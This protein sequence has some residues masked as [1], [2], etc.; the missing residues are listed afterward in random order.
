[1]GK[2]QYR[3]LIF[4]TKGKE[5][6]RLSQAFLEFVRTAANPIVKKKKIDIDFFN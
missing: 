1:M 2:S 5:S 3:L 4:S 6:R